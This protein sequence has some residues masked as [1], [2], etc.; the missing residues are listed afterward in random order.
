[1]LLDINVLLWLAYFACT[2]VEK[3]GYP[4]SQKSDPHLPGS[5]EFDQLLIQYNQ[6]NLLQ[7]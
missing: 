7:K 1:M 2:L 4:S 6:Q 3:W 5:D